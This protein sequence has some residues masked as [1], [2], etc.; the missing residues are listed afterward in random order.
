[1]KKIILISATIAALA[2][3]PLFAQSTV[4]VN[5]SIAP[6]CSTLSP[7]NKALGDISGTAPGSLDASKVNVSAGSLGA[8]TCNGAG[9]TISIDA[10]PLEGPA[11]PS[12]AAAAGFTNTISYTATVNKVGTAYTSAISTPA[13]VSSL[14]S[15]PAATTA[16]AGLIAGSFTVDLTAAAATGLLIASGTAGYSG[17]ITV[18]LTAG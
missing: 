9:T 7:I 5:G 13:V 14:T 1:M 16:T 10:N 15:D 17:T 6:K 2:G 3:S 8:I 4:T 11:L 18:S 12:G